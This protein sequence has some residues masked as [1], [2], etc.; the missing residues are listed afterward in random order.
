[1]HLRLMPIALRCVVEL[2]VEL[3]PVSLVPL[4]FPEIATYFFISSSTV[5][6]AASTRSTMARLSSSC[7]RMYLTVR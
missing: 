3:P 6:P 5:P 7:S 2:P 1:M 4:W